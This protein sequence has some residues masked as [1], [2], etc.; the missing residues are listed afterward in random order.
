MYL[1]R[2]DECK[3]EVR[4]AGAGPRSY[5]RTV[6]LM[7]GSDMVFTGH[8]CCAGCAKTMLV[9]AAEGLTPKDLE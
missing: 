5:P 6:S 3:K 8:A 1:V 2:C 7:M 4:A 9:R